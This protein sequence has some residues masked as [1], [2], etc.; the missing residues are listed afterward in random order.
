MEVTSTTLIGQARAWLW[1][2][3]C[4]PDAF[5]LVNFLQ[6]VE[7]FLFLALIRYQALAIEAILNAGKLPT[8]RVESISI[9][10]L[11]PRNCGMRFS[12]GS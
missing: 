9:H 1:P 3:F 7:R 6:N 11:I 5:F 12:M 2:L 10:G 8:G 4:L